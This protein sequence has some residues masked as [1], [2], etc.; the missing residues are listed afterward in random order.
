M[1]PFFFLAIWVGLVALIVVVGEGRLSAEK[2]DH[3]R[4]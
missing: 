4:S 3:K 1:V 2:G